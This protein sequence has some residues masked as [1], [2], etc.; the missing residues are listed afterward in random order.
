MQLFGV[1]FIPVLL[2]AGVA[3]F[4]RWT[5]TWKE[6]LLQLGIQTLVLTGAFYLAKQRSL[7][8]TEHLHGRI[9]KKVHD[10]ES[11][12]HCREVCTM[13]TTDRTCSSRDKNGNCTS[14]S[15]TERCVAWRTECDHS[16]DYYWS[17]KT[18]LGT[19][20]INDCEPDEDDVPAIWANAYVGEPVA[21]EHSYQNYLLADKNSLLV[22][23]VERFLDRV[24]EYPKIYGRYK[25]NPVV[26]MKAPDGWQQAFREINADL[27]SRR[28]VDVTVVMTPI[29]DPTFAQAL[30]AKWLYGPKNSLNVVLGV[31]GG[32]IS[33][34]RVVTFSKVES[35]KVYLRD[36]LQG[37]RLT[38]DVPGIIRRA[39]ESRFR[40]TAMADYEYLVRAA[41]L[42]TGWMVFLYVFGLLLSGGLG[43]YMHKN[44]VFGD[45][46]VRWRMR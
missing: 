37:K 4:L 14:Y 11:C 45:E 33:W 1:L 9:T 13:H 38:D 31:R 42:P 36:E 6:F 5:V 16:R 24:P 17:L 23:E 25:V 10:S 34:A 20:T 22:H 29:Q 43:L 35:L 12:C 3:F 8:D 15:E 26:G 32:E 2:A 41:S 18:T 44:D 40:R 7:T 19:M 46:G 39:V 28:Q 30:E 21:K 27:G